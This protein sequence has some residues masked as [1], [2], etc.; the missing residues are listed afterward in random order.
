M[1]SHMFQKT[2]H[3]HW[4]ESSVCRDSVSETY[5]GMPGVWDKF[6]SSNAGEK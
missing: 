6:F 5:I 4:G 3:W 2:N 1:C